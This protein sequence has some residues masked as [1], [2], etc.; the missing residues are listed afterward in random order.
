M[1]KILITTIVTLTICPLAFSQEVKKEYY[2]NG[3]I[4]FERTFKDGKLQGEYKE[5]YPNGVLKNV[6]IF[7]AGEVEGVTKQYNENGKLTAE[8]T[9]DR[10]QMGWWLTK[11]YEYYPGGSLK[12]EYMYNQKT[13]EGYRKDFYE[14][15][16]MALEFIIKGQEFLDCKNYDEKGNF[17]ST[18]CPEK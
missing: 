2:E 17:L 11:Q 16:Q 3:K 14:N 7:V 1:K 9:R 18:E 12:S 5:F 6:K 4:H 8:L 10:G 13:Q 15:G